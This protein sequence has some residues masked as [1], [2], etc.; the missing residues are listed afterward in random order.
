MEI[1]LQELIDQ[2]KKNGVEVAESEAAAI[3]DAARAEAQAILAEAQSKADQMLSAAKAEN[4]RLLRVSEEAIRQA[5]RNVLLSFRESVTKELHA[6]L[7]EN[8][9]AVYSSE[10]FAELIMNVVQAWT[11]KGGK[12]DLSVILSESDLARLEET[13]LS[14][15]KAKL[16]TG[17]ILR[18]S[19]QLDGG[20]RIAVQ[21]G[22]AYYDYSPEAVVEMMSAYLSPKVTAYLKEAGKA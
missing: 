1:Q 21:D 10:T 7:N 18:A 16:L 8:V 17:V 4:E 14:A 3:V 15:M 6:I 20:F 19:G 9:A 11:D 12:E 13:L 22:R 5:G 2:I